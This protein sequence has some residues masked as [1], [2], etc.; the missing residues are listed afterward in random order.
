MSHN[1][2]GEPDD[3]EPLPDW[4][5]PNQPTRRPS[6]S[7]TDIINDTMKKPPIPQIPDEPTNTPE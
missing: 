6:K 1:F 3:I 2:W 5:K 4:M 7:I